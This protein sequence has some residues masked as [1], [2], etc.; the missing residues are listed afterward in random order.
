MAETTWRVSDISNATMQDW[1]TI[2][3]VR[4]TG[5]QP[6]LTECGHQIPSGLF[7]TYVKHPFGDTQKVKK[8]FVRST[9]TPVSGLGTEYTKRYSKKGY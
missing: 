6:P 3:V 1:W 4:S 9:L 8:S 7:L 2:P 5:L